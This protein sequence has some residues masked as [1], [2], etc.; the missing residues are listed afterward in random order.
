MHMSYR[1]ARSGPCPPWRPARREGLAQE[2]HGFTLIELMIVVAII[3]VLAALAVPNFFAYRTKSK[4]SAVI[5]TS[6]L[7]RA[8]L[9][10]YAAT[11]PDT[12][13]PP[14]AAITDFAS[15]Q[16]LLRDHGGTLTHTT[17]FTLKSYARF[18]SNGNG[19][20][21]SYAMRLRVT[22][23]PATVE[24][25]EVLVTPTGILRCNTSLTPC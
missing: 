22:G 17:N 12:L 23:V 2:T 21:D 20:E 14:S 6:E 4:V 10:S 9:A 13:Y 19:E 15:L 11:S 8:S 3:A 25:F 5:G 16:A 24:G 1:P 7:I 18:D